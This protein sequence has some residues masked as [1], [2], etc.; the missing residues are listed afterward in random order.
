MRSTQVIKNLISRPA[1]QGRLRTFPEPKP[2]KQT[3]LQLWKESSRGRSRVLKGVTLFTLDIPTLT[4][5]I[6]GVDTL[7]RDKYQ[8]IKSKLQ[9][10]EQHLRM[11]VHKQGQTHTQTA[12][13]IHMWLQGGTYRA[14][15][16]IVSMLN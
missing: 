11:R 6:E 16:C 1:G 4:T 2:W 9:M 5:I 14:L 13:C 10:E 7:P 8:G 15:I 3:E 12:V